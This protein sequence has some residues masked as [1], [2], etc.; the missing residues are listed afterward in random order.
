MGAPDSLFSTIV[1]LSE[2][3][4]PIIHMTSQDWPKLRD[5]VVDSILQALLRGTKQAAPGFPDAD[6]SLSLRLATSALAKVSLR[7]SK[8]LNIVLSKVTMCS[9]VKSVAFLLQHLLTRD[10][11]L[12]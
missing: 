10:A 7:R 9:Y 2:D 1:V 11:L 5:S 6:F 8:F 4:D 12:I 3:A